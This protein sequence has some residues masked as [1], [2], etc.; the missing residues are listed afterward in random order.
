[1]PASDLVC[2]L[3]SYVRSIA[4]RHDCKDGRKF[5]VF[6]VRSDLMSMP[7]I[8]NSLENKI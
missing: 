5:G 7:K 4:N 8:S 2:L 6:T 1:M 3:K